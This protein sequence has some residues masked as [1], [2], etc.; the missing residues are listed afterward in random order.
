MLLNQIQLLDPHL[1][2][3]NL[4]YYFNYKST[5]FYTLKIRTLIYKKYVFNTPLNTYFYR[6]DYYIN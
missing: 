3:I 5:Y 6:I 1:S 2:K 4:Q